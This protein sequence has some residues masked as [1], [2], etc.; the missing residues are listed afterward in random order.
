MWISG[1][2]G[3]TQWLLGEE[4]D[5]ESPEYHCYRAAGGSGVGN[6]TCVELV[7]R[8]MVGVRPHHVGLTRVPGGHRL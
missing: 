8:E 5:S 1:G 2:T 7:G 4:T 3:D 6:V